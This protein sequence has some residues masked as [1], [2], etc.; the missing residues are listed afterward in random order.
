MFLKIALGTRLY[1]TLSNVLQIGQKYYM[2]T[3][4]EGQI[5]GGA[6]KKAS[7]RAAAPRISGG[8]PTR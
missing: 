6:T 4:P 5:L 8:C 1:W 2:D 7:G 3:E